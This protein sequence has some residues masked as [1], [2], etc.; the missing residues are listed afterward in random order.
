MNIFETIQMYAGKWQVKS[1]REFSD[2]EKSLVDHIEVQSSQYGKSACFFMK[3][4]QMGFIPL[5]SDSELVTPIGT[6]LNID[7][8]VVKTLSRPGDADIQRIVIK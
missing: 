3:N 2:I 7:N 6:I 4:G 8:L 5:D 1:S